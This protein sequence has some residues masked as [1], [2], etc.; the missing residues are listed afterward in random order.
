[1]SKKIEHE[2][3]RLNE[4]RDLDRLAHLEHAT[5]FSPTE[6][7]SPAD[8]VGPLDFDS[9]G[10][11]EMP[12]RAK[13]GQ[14]SQ[15]TPLGGVYGAFD[16]TVTVP[17]ADGVA[18][19]PMSGLTWVAVHPDMRRRGVLRALMS[20]HLNRVHDQGRY[21]VAGLH[22]SDPGIYG[23]FGYEVAS[24]DVLYNL[25]HG[26]TLQAPQAISDAA[27]ALETTLLPSDGPGVLDAIHEAHQRAGGV[28]LGAAVRSAGLTKG[29]Y[30]DFPKARGS[31]EKVQVVFALQDGQPVGYAS[32]RRNS[33]WS[34]VGVASGS[35]T[36]REI[37]A[38]SEAAL[39]A[40]ARRLTTLDLTTS[41]KVWGRRMD[42]P[43]MWWAGGPRNVGVRMGDSLWLRLVDLPKALAQRG[44]AAP[45][46][47]VLGIADEYCPWNSGRWRLTINEAGQAHCSRTQDNADLELPV[48]ALAAAYL[49]GRSLVSQAPIHGIV[50]HTDGALTRLSRA[51]R[52]DI[53]P[54]GSIG[55]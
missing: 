10:A 19:I 13:F 45:V 34:D 51:M 35:V 6:G 24:Y 20:D 38:E 48:Q 39:L 2:V 28:S 4:D 55:F 1:M 33:E 53:E 31:K 47:V 23:R 30:R 3:I 46:D 42:D 52:S 18:P 11:V 21:A 40:L 29:D 22:A 37:F 8:A 14:T 50:E 43:L 7:G 32:F 17:T 26:A 27:G 5:W 54:I 41:I 44:Y 16:M 49:G 15:T 9:T 12:A 25:S 36:M